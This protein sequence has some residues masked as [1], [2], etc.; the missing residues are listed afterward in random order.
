MVIATWV[1]TCHTQT[2]T[3]TT[4]H[5]HTQKFNISPWVIMIMFEGVVTVDIVGLTLIGEVNA[6][7]SGGVALVEIAA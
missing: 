4:L 2:E 3:Y 1:N 7:W 5:T 6:R